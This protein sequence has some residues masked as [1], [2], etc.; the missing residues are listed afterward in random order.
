MPLWPSPRI[1]PVSCNARR[2]LRL[3]CRNELR[4]IY[5]GAMRSDEV[6]E[7]QDDQ[8][9][10]A[11]RIKQRKE[12]DNGPLRDQ[13]REGDEPVSFTPHQTSPSPPNKTSST[14]PDSAS[15]EPTPNQPTAQPIR[16]VP[17]KALPPILKASD[18][19]PKPPLLRRRPHHH[20]H[21]DFSALNFEPGVSKTRSFDNLAKKQRIAPFSV[22][23]ARNPYA[24]ALAVPSR[25]CGFTGTRLPRSCMLDFHVVEK[26]G[27]D[28]GGE[29]LDLQPLSLYAA[30]VRPKKSE[31]RMKGWEK[32]ATAAEVEE[33]AWARRPTGTAS[34]V[35]ARREALEFVSAAP[36]S[37]VRSH[38]MSLRLERQ[39][40]YEEGGREGV[41]WRGDMPDFVLEWMRRI[42]VRRLKYLINVKGAADRS[43][44]VQTMPG[45]AG[46]E[47]LDE[48]DD[49]IC[50]LR[51]TLPEP[52][53]ESK[54]LM[55][56]NGF[57]ED[58]YAEIH[59]W[60]DQENPVGQPET[61]LEP[62]E[63]K[64]DTDDP[65]WQGQ[66]DCTADSK[67]DPDARQAERTVPP[68]EGHEN[69][70]PSQPPHPPASPDTAVDPINAPRRPS[71]TPS[72]SPPPNP[73]ASKHN[74]PPSTTTSYKPHGPTNRSRTRRP[75]TGPWSHAENASFIGDLHPL[76]PP[77]RPLTL[78]Y[79]TLRYRNRRVAAYNLAFLLGGE[80]RVREVL[81]GTVFEGC[82]YV[83][84]RMDGGTVELA[85]GL[86]R[87]QS[88][89]AGEKE[90]AVR[91]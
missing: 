11:L 18:L 48:V 84:V 79:P 17:S 21:H 31:G 46:L 15:C 6:L 89:L 56:H 91:V 39:L 47:R 42:V 83:V 60:Q 36:G 23:F 53:E 34:Y 71:E 86:L 4:R 2:A 88:Y 65:S 68:T 66:R 19:L 27:A 9:V 10:S 87:L 20:P 3:G 72:A 49:V 8:G 38:V 45:N 24:R 12:A 43:G 81:G 40:E 57:E 54:P 41:G 32:R 51:T 13:D 16:R 50:V 7:V 80:E 26:V 25:R 63:N 76:P 75:F 22:A 78:Y 29:G 58:D 70:T 55:D 35:V 82:K 33:E 61:Q 5:H 62:A 64:A 85:V 67:D 74:Q 52:G 59:A 44:N 14:L 73:N 77:K 1:P 28:G 30:A 37:R 90:D 69:N